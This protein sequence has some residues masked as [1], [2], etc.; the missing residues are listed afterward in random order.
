MNEEGEVLLG[1]EVRNF[2]VIYSRGIRGGCTDSLIIPIEYGAIPA[3]TN[4]SLSALLGMTIRASNRN[5]L[6]FD[7]VDLLYWC[8]ELY[9]M[10]LPLST[11]AFSFLLA[12]F[13]HPPSHHTR[14]VF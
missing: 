11:A 13:F 12:P 10:A 2:M 6:P 14:R 4:W 5:N 7:I 3:G 9:K 8:L 1:L